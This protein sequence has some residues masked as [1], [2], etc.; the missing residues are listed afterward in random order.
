M[1]PR[2]EPLNPQF[3]RGS[4]CLYRYK[5]RRRN[6][7]IT[8]VYIYIY[9]YLCVCVHICC[10]FQ[11]GGIS[12]PFEFDTRNYKV[13]LRNPGEKPYSISVW[14]SF[15]DVVLQH[16]SFNNSPSLTSPYPDA[17]CAYPERVMI[18]IPVPKRLKRG[19]LFIHQG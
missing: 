16:R 2:L 11:K 5:N 6:R 7:W 9:L 19:G 17:F 1:A 14:S 4:L 10:H 15:A 13:L 12:G 3:P 8:Y 18:G